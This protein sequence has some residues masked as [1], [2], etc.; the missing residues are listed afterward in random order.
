MESKFLRLGHAGHLGVIVLLALMLS[1]W[2]VQ[3]GDQLDGRKASRPD[4]LGEAQ[5]FLEAADSSMQ[6]SPMLALEYAVKAEVLARRAN[7][8]RLLP[9][10]LM[11]KGMASYYVGDLGSA[12]EAL[13]ESKAML[14]GGEDKEILGRLYNDLAA[15][16]RYSG[17]QPD[18]AL[19]YYKRAIDVFQEAAERGGAPHLYAKELSAIYSNIGQV[20]AE[21]KDYEQAVSYFDQSLAVSSGAEGY[22]RVRTA[23][24]ISLA[25]VWLGTGQLREADSLLYD[26][27][28][29][30]QKEEDWVLHSAALFYKGKLLE[31]MND[32]DSA[33][34]FYEQALAEAQSVE[35]WT[36]VKEFALKL[37]DLARQMGRGAEA[38]EHLMLVQD[39][40][41]RIGKGEAAIALSKMELEEK[42]RAW[43]EEVVLQMGRSRARYLLALSLAAIAGFALLLLYVV[44]VRKHRLAQL[45][46][47]E[48]ELQRRQLE[49][50]REGLAAEVEDT[51]QQLALNLLERM[52][53]NE[54]VNETLQ[55]LMEVYRRMPT[56]SSRES[57]QAIT[58]SL[59]NIQD[60]SLWEDFEVLYQRSHRGFFE[61][62]AGFGLTSNECRLCV[63]LRTNS[64]LPLFLLLI[65]T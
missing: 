2:T 50:E 51:K 39:A 53:A 47:L 26:A 49:I 5:L 60:H 25:D 40:E 35:V 46:Y 6:S 24:K 58:H 32:L 16:Y 63:F 17:F 13:I 34:L 61:A 19:V 3:G 56:V 27:L 64:H 36:S 14:K 43:E 59:R 10:A 9:L 48:S 55:K 29:V 28:A 54:M 52:S 30:A 12:A 38:Y 11:K 57:L 8:N 42:Y 4:A 45:K 41:D 31:R 62:L 1:P 7:D 21:E 20:Y 23:T 33:Y 37:S 15:V 22:D 65:L 44:V 18:S